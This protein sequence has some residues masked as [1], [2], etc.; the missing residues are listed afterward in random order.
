[1]SNNAPTHLSRKARQFIKARKQLSAA[2]PIWGRLWGGVGH[3][4]WAAEPCGNPDQLPPAGAAG[5]WTAAAPAA[6]PLPAATE[7]RSSTT[8][9]HSPHGNSAPPTG[10]PLPAA[11]AGREATEDVAGNHSRAIPAFVRD[12]HGCGERGRDS[13]VSFAR[14]ASQ[15]GVG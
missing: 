7:Q 10:R 9:N 1:M 12:L 8:A 2:G 14:L 5:E 15:V 6:R 3:R 11:E 4:R 13:Y